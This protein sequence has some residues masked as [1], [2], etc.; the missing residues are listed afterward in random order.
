[1]INSATHLLTTCTVSLLHRF[2]VLRTISVKSR[3][4]I[5]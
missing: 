5:S 1:M 2:E 3:S 4:K